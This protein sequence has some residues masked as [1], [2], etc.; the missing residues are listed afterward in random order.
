MIAERRDAYLDEGWGDVVIVP[1][2]EYFSTWEYCKAPK[3]KGGRVYIEVRDNGEIAF[4]EGYVTAKEAKRL[5][6]GEAIDSGP[7]AVRPEVSSTMPTYLDLHRH[8]AV[9]AALCLNSQ[10]AL[11]IGTPAGGDKR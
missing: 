8:P 11:H 5:E 9:S 2:G 7:K 1:R 3:R 4:H 10:V 6:S